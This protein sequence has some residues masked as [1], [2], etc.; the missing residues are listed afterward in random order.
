MT[1]ITIRALL[2][3]PCFCAAENTVS[4][5]T[6]LV[7]YSDNI[8]GAVFSL[9]HV[10]RRNAVAGG[11]DLSLNFAWDTVIDQNTFASAFCWF[12]NASLPAGGVR[13]NRSSPGTVVA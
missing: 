8:D 13:Y 11:V 2:H 5:A 3:S 4:C 6:E 12:P 7:A 9:G 10:F 1:W